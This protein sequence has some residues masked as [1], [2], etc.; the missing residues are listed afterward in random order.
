[1]VLQIGEP[2][3]QRQQGEP[4]VRLDGVLIGVKVAENALFAARGIAGPDAGD[5]KSYLLSLDLMLQDNLLACFEKGISLEGLSLNVGRTG[6]TGNTVFG[7]RE[8]AIVAS[9]AVAAGGMEIARNLLYPSGNGIVTGTSATRI[10]ANDVVALAETDAVRHGIVLADGLDPLGAQDCQVTGN[11]VSEMR[12]NAIAVPGRIRSAMIKQNIVR[13]CG[14]GIVMDANSKAE[15]VT[16]DNNQLGELAPGRDKVI[17]PVTAIRAIRVDHLRIAGNAIRGVATSA[18]SGSDVFSTVTGIDVIGCRG[19]TLSGNDL[20][21]IGADNS[22][23]PTFA[24]RL[25][26]PL[27]SAQVSD[28]VVRREPAGTS[29]GAMWTA[30][31][32]GTTKAPPVGGIALPAGEPRRAT[33]DKKEKPQDADQQLAFGALVPGSLDWQGKMSPLPSL[34]FIG[35]ATGLFV[36]EPTAISAAPVLPRVHL[37]VQGNQFFAA[38][39]V[40]PA[41]SIEWPDACNFA[42]N[43]CH[44]GVDITY[45]TAVELA[46]AKTAISGNVVRRPNDTDAIRVTA[47]ANQVTVIGNLTYGNIRLNGGALPAPWSALNVIAS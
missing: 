19:S 44:V 38:G 26:P 33:T 34:Q 1:V 13:R 17:D 14:G 11:H 15:T 20:D 4:A 32:I 23:V 45:P 37:G 35:G 31:R 47:F 28:N 39:G 8:A 25:H 40:A 46:A 36:V 30:L 29:S 10:D 6:L 18:V 5:E 12:G 2:E 43:Q 7:C 41:V 9:G 42:N 16:I 27:V 22:L 3:P 21:E 24:I